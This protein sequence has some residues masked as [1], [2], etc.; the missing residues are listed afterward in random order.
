M[1]LSLSICLLPRYSL[2]LTL[3]LFSLFYYLLY[4]TVFFISLSLSISLFSSLPLSL[5][6]LLSFSYFL[7]LSL[8]LSL[9][10]SLSL[11]LRHSLMVCYFLSRYLHLPRFYL[12][13]FIHWSPHLGGYPCVRGHASLP[14]QLY[15][16]VPVRLQDTGYQENAL[17]LPPLFQK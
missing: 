16:S 17:A 15:Q 2:S 3:S 5:F 12:S 6:L 11:S 10:Y 4:Q 8:P 14:Q 9:S 1:S 7:P 13:A